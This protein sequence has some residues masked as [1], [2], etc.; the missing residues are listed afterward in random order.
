MLF[1]FS[2]KAQ[3]EAVITETAHTHTETKTVSARAESYTA[4]HTRTDSTARTDSTVETKIIITEYDTGQP[5]NPVKKRTEIIQKKESKT[6]ANKTINNDTKT[7]EKT[8]EKTT[9]KS[10]TDT[11]TIVKEKKSVPLKNTILTVVIILFALIAIFIIIRF[12]PF[13]RIILQSL[14]KS[15]FK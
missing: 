7:N 15:I 8:N 5:N 4:A 13:L 1:L 9:I 10:D 3:K 11:K 12:Y 2:C 6:I 14:F